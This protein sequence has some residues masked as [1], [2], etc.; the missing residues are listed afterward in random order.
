MRWDIKKFRPTL[1]VEVIR[2]YVAASLQEHLS[3][4]EYNY[5]YINEPFGGG[6]YDCTIHSDAYQRVKTLI[7]CKYGNYLN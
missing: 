1:I 2:D 5:F 6:D 4:L 3:E 7:N